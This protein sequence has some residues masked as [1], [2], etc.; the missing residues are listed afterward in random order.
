MFTYVRRDF[1]DGAN[2]YDAAILY[3]R[4]RQRQQVWQFGLNP[5]E[6]SDFVAEYGWR[7]IEQAGPDYYLHN[8]IR[9]SGRDLGASQLEWAGYAEKV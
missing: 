3:K 4:F 2:M 8:Y 9:P 1:I 6:V 7:L 5:D